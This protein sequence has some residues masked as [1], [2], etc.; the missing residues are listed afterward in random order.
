MLSKLH[1]T[2]IDSI[3][4]LCRNPSAYADPYQELQDILLRSYGLSASQRTGKWLDHPGLGNNKPSVLWDQLNAPQPA[5]VK[6]VQTVLFLPKLPA[7][8]ET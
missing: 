2:L 1:F 3:A 4:P 7:T 5:T 8:S 6:E